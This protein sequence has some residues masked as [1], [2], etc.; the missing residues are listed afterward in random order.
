MAEIEALGKEKERLEEEIAKP[1]N[2]SDGKKISQLLA[3]KDELESR[4]SEKE[5]RWMEI[6]EEMENGK[7]S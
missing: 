4:I 7:D 1:E 5:E 3:E 6:S 2:Y